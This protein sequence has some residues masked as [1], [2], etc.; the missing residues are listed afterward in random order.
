MYEVRSGFD[1]REQ[2]SMLAQCTLHINKQ[3]PLRPDTIE[4]VDHY[5]ID[6]FIN[7]FSE[8]I[9]SRSHIVQG[10][11]LF[12]THG[13]Q[14]KHLFSVTLFSDTGTL[15]VCKNNVTAYEVSI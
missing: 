5:L 9:F 12:T 7:D 6:I 13:Q 4:R 15:S 2:F 3:E 14:Y 1:C 10:N 11:S 8:I